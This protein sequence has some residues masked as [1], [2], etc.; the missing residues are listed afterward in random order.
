MIAGAIV[1]LVVDF[2]GRPILGVDTV[3]DLPNAWRFLGFLILIAIALASAFMGFMASGKGEAADQES[4]RQKRSSRPAH[5]RAAPLRRPWPRWIYATVIISVVLTAFY[6]SSLVE[7]SFA[8]NQNR[9]EPSTSVEL[10]APQVVGEDPDPDRS[11]TIRK[12]IKLVPEA[13]PVT[14]T[15]FP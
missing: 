3:S 6:V 1:R 12:K 5:D 2:A 14:G 8:D 4:K 11:K 15:T 13:R 9:S 10:S 7:L